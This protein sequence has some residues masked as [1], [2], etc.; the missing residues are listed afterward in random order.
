MT[1]K[2]KY[3]IILALSTAVISDANTFLAKTAITIL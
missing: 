3:A 1:K 2:L